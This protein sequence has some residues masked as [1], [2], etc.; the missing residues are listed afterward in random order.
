MAELMRDSLQLVEKDAQAIQTA[1]PRKVR[2]ELRQDKREYRSEL[3]RRVNAQKPLNA[4]RQEI[5]RIQ[6]EQFEPKYFGPIILSTRLPKPE[7]PWPDPDIESQF[8]AA[9]GERL[10]NM[11][12]E[13]SPK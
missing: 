4:L 7:D 5:Q 1:K 13:L 11:P 12:V 3:R 9:Y 10:I 8:L 2:K 6:N